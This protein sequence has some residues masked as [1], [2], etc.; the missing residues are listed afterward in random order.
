MLHFPT[1][2]II[3][4]SITILDHFTKVAVMGGEKQFGDIHLLWS[5]DESCNSWQD[6][7]VGADRTGRSPWTILNMVQSL[8]GGVT[9]D[10][11]SADLG[12]PADQEIFHTLRS[13][14]DV[15]LVGAETVRKEDYG[16]PKLTAELQ[17]QRES[18][19]QQ[20]QPEIAVVSASLALDPKSRLFEGG[21]RPVVFTCSG[22]SDVCADDSD[23]DDAPDDARTK[24]AASSSENPAASSSTNSPEQSAD[25]QSRYEALS[26]A[27]EVIVLESSESAE[28]SVSD[29]WAAVDLSVAREALGARGH[30][31]ILCEG[32]PTL[33]AQLVAQDLIDEF[34]ISLSPALL[35]GNPLHL[36]EDAPLLNKR[37]TLLSIATDN[38][39]LFLR[40][41]Q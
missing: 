25:R 9:S 33:N 16:P 3:I 34:C 31:V 1:C 24:P 32:G 19:G 36:L 12:S 30:K 29:V 40:Y 2:C 6:A 5:A 22:T 20:P 27:A 15:I 26:E 23:A 37:L 28:N 7:Y 38:A 39:L 41:G 35:G 13:L 4:S 21:H 14:A 10:D 8:D 17:A 11:V 18:R